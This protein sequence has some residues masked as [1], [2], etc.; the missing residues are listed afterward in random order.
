VIGIGQFTS[1]GEKMNNEQTM[2]NV[3]KTLNVTPEALKERVTVLLE[4]QGPAWVNAGKSEDDC[5]LLAIRVAARQINTEAAALRR[6]GAEVIEG[7]FIHS[8]RP[9]EWGKIL[10]NKMK[11]QLMGADGNAVHALVNSGAIVTFEDNHDGTYHRMAMDE[12]GGESDV[13]ELPRHTMRLDENTHF[14]VVW[15]KSNPTFPSGDV[16]FKYGKP[17]PQDERERTS[18]FLTTDMKLVTVKAQGKAADIQHPTFVTGTIPVRM[19]QNGT[20]AYCK[21][22]VSVF[23]VDDSLASKYPSAPLDLLSSDDVP[24][25]VLDSFDALVSYYDT[26][27][28][29]PGWWD[30]IVAVPSEVIHID[31]RDNGGMVLVCA[32]LDLA[33]TAPTVDVYVSE[34]QSVDFAVGTKCLIVGQTWRTQDNEQRMSVGGWWAYDIIESMEMHSNLD[35]HS[36]SIGVMEL[37][38]YE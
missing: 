27:N 21:P 15:D 25:D 36:E 2:N 11:N 1:K 24:V 30:R 17:R 16:N 18:L 37:S 38:D 22:E 9:K 14:Y 8:P 3:A 34:D 26:H 5:E 33:S 19:G 28:G 13:S 23:S 35:A 6:A 4:E 10:Y 7:M 31:P 29:Q 20:T 32:D 12:F